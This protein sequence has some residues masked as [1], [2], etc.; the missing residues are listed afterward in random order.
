MDR[1]M[2]RREAPAALKKAPKVY[3]W[4]R[5]T[6]EDGCYFRAIKADVRYRLMNDL[7]IQ[8]DDGRV[9]LAF[10]DEESGT[11]YIN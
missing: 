7:C 10:T 6:R 3:V 9:I 2:S 11:L 5:G 1:V 4:V 8:D